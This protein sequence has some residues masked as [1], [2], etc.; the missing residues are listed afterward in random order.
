[1]STMSADTV[2]AW[3]GHWAQTLTGSIDLNGADP[4][5]HALRRHWANR[6]ALLKACGQIVDVGS[7]PAILARLMGSLGWALEHPKTWWCVD[8]A[9]L[10][11]GWQQ[12]L[13][14]GVRVLDGLKFEQ[15][16]P[17]AGPV[18]AM[19]SNF[20]LE[21]LDR[22]GLVHALP[23]WLRPHGHLEAV[24]HARGSLI[25]KVSAEH[26]SDLRLAL[27]ELELPQRGLDLVQALA[28]AP[29]DP[30][31]RMMHGVGVRDAYNA[32][33]DQLKQ[34][35]EARGRPSAVLMDLLGG[36]TRAIREVRSSGAEGASEAISRLGRSL[37]AE[38]ARLQ[39][40]QACALDERQLSEWHS[41][42]QGTMAGP[43]RLKVQR[44]DCALGLVAWNLSMAA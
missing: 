32:A 22:A 35:M 11:Q 5:A 12:A 15:S 3:T 18:D 19:V 26:A 39:Q 27:H 16:R 2:Q 33:V 38:W 42:L 31:L 28:T 40:M 43:Q 6:V 30:V 13:P 23:H 41:A 25:D 1:M 4:V 21:Y 34:R 10:G 14:S 29:T 37:E 44:I 9:R 24:L 17:P 36:I 8:Q 7:G 20:G